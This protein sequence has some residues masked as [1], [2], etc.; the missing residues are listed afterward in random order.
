ML[1]AP[2]LRKNRLG[3]YIQILNSSDNGALNCFAQKESYEKQHIDLFLSYISCNTDCVVLDVGANYGQY[4]LAAANIG[5]YGSVNRILAFEPDSVPYKCLCESIQ[6]NGFTGFFVVIQTIIGDVGGTGD[7]FK[8]GSSSLSNRTFITKSQA[9]ASIGSSVSE[10]C[11]I[12]SIDELLTENGISIRGYRF[13]IKIDI[14][15]NE[16]K[17][18]RGASKLLD[19]CLG[20]VIQFEYYPFA[21][22]EAS[23]DPEDFRELLSSLTY[24]T[25]LLFKESK[26]FVLS[27]EEMFSIMKNL[28]NAAK[29]TYA[30]NFI[31]VKN[32]LHPSTVHATTSAAGFPVK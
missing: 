3:G 1:A 12:A 11:R 13:F 8:S 6:I 17:A 10:R 27:R 32:C 9:L 7:L 24:D 19:K 18:L 26:L 22:L 30:E 15:G 4:S 2:F 29:P 21:M 14:E 20:Y 23:E 28:D 31:I 25:I 5:R 16:P